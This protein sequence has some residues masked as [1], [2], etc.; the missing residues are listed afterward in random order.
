MLPYLPWL[1]DKIKRC[2]TAH[3]IQV[4][5]KPVRKLGNLLTSIKDPV[6]IKSRQGVVYSISCRDCNKR[7]IGE[8]KV[9]LET[10][11][12]EL[13]ADVKNKQFEK[14]ASTQ[15]T[16]DLNHWIDWDNSKVLCFEIWIKL[17]H[18]PICR[19]RSHFCDKDTMH[20]KTSDL[21]PDI[22]QFMLQ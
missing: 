21:F 15:H 4:A 1:T 6:D 2:L 10:R 12:K 18:T 9:S 17:L 13:E 7:Y 16:F 8:T 22:Y 14:S 3:K 20:E 19:I 5:S 11:Q